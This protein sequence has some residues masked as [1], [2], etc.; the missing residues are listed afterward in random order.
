M[1]RVDNQP[2]N[3]PTM[4]FTSPAVGIDITQDAPKQINSLAQRSIRSG[5]VARII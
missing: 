3:R 5:L 1:K 4:M 2:K